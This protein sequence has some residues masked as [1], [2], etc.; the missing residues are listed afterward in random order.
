MRRL[1]RIFVSINAAV[2]IGC[3][4]SMALVVGA[5]VALRY[6]TNH[7]LSWADESAR[8]LMIWMT[9]LGA[10][11]AL[12]QGGHVA[13]TNL[14]DVMTTKAQRLLR[15]AIVLILLLFFGFMVFVG[16][17]Y[18]QR[19]QFQMTPALRLSFRY[20]YTAIPVGFSLL[21]VHLLLV[22]KPF[23]LAGHYIQPDGQSDN[24]PGPANG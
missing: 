15:T 14:H 6:T 18:M 3:L 20:V 2:V 12:R 1:E 16:W 19:A 7:S 8:Y 22:A 23:I 24:L 4:S 11:L 17:E 13:I 5:N 10:G 21:I 9:F